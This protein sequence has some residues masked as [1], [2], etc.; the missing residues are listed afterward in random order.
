MK[1]ILLTLLAAGA[2]APTFAQVGMKNSWVAYASGLYGSTRGEFNSGGISVDQPS[3]RQ[4]AINPGLGYQ[5]TDRLAIGVNFELSGYK[6][7]SRDNTPGSRESVRSR[8]IV[9]GPFVR[10]TMPLGERFFW[11]TQADFGYT[12]G[13]DREVINGTPDIENEIDRNGVRGRLFPS[14]GVS[15]SRTMSLAFNVGGIQYEYERTDFGLNQEQKN[16]TLLV[17][18][19]QVVGFTVQ[20]YFGGRRYGGSRQPMDETRRM[21]TSDDDE[22]DDDDRPRRRRNRD[23]D[24][25]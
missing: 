23:K 1:K 22:E 25:E 15:F 9:V 17:N 24:D 11:F 7:E 21:D 6:I 2:L 10:Y 14:V 4:L 3:Y 13:K 12:S 18:F 16:S 19:G 5:F 20:K 8:D